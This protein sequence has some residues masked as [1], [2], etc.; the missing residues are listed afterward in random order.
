MYAVPSDAMASP[1]IGQPVLIVSWWERRTVRPGCGQ[2]Q[3]VRRELRRRHA[4]RR[5][6]ADSDRG[7][8][9]LRW[10]QRDDD[11]AAVVH[12][13]DEHLVQ[14]AHAHRSEAVDARVR[15]ARR[16]R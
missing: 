1:A 2:R 11:L 3:A 16:H 12:A 8:R 15:R 6:V 9:Q 5:E 13:V 4:D 14:V 7:A 10:D